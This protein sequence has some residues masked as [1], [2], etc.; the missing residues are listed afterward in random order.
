MAYVSC[1]AKLAANIAQ[2]C[3][4]PIVGGYTG[5][6]IL[7]PLSQVTPTIVQDAGNP[8]KITSSTIGESD[9]VVFVDNVS[10]TPFGGSTTAGNADSGYPEFTKTMA[11]RIPMRGA[12]V[13]RDVVEPMFDDPMGFLGIFPKRDKVADGS[14]EVVGFLNPLRGD[15]TSLTRDE[16]A[17]GGA[18]ELNLTCTESWAEV[19]LVGVDGTYSSALAIYE[20]LKSKA[21]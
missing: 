15:I 17:N 16:N 13:S 12:M 6:G 19:T 10:A 5:S 14:F 21:F 8:R 7:I 9:K 20:Q 2:D 11:I 18:W 3:E 4:H 1:A